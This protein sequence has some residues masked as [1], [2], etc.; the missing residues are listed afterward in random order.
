[1]AVDAY[2]LQSAIIWRS[3]RY[4][5]DIGSGV[6]VRSYKI[7][8]SGEAAWLYRGKTKKQCIRSFFI[9]KCLMGLQ[10]NGC[11][12][13]TPKASIIITIIIISSIVIIIKRSD[14]SDM[15]LCLDDLKSIRARN[16]T[17]PN[18]PQTGRRHIAALPRMPRTHCIS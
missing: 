10:T 11:Q 8:V 14:T 15:V 17:L 5:D 16:P 1:M 6:G 3:A 18:V 2:M 4:R 12:H 13:G 7:K 9:V